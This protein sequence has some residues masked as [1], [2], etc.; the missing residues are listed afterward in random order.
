M[1]GL[2]TTTA[3]AVSLTALCA[4]A[5]PASAACVDDG[6][7]VTCTGPGNA[8]ISD[9]TDGKSFTIEP[10]AGI[11]PLNGRALTLSGDDQSVLNEGL[12]ESLDDEAVRTTGARLTFENAGQIRA[13][14]DRGIRLQAGAD[15][16]T[17]VNRAR[18]TILT[19]DQAIRADNGDLL[20]NLRV[21]NAGTITS[22]KGRAIQS[23][24]PGTTVINTGDLFGGEEVIEARTDFT[25]EN[26]GTI[27]IIDPTIADEDGVQFASGR[28]D[29]HGLIQGTDD[30]IDVDE[31]I[32]NNH[33]GGVIQSLPAPG[34]DGGNGIDADDVLQ[35][36]DGD[37]PAGLLTIDNAGLI[38]GAKAIG[39]DEN[40]TAAI[41]VINS[42]TLRGTSGVA[43]DLAPLQEDSS[44][45]LSG[46]SQI[47]GDV[48]FGS[49]DDL[50][51]VGDVTSG[52]LI[53]SAFDGG[54]GDNTVRFTD[55]MLASVTTAMFDGT[56][57]SLSL[58]TENGLI[59]GNFQ[60][61]GFWQF[62]DDEA[63]STAQLRD[64]LPQA[65]PV[66]LP[67]GLPLLVTALGG[68]AWLRRRTG[69]A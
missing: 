11:G 3:M 50:V 62:G 52:P 12:I 57:I 40:R 37:A 10:G 41:D 13:T 48:I 14:D 28:V 36:P 7:T 65:T 26:R 18:A 39:V 29:N 68:L 34:E 31:G 9:A 55:L 56:K 54:T 8:A 53:N 45:T 30:G 35:T 2:T 67:T 22:T 61:F 58:A 6:T 49:G 20:E 27:Q 59:S 46:D 17:I 5:G 15:D 23:R 19:E 47:F 4:F 25:L 66:P 43:I 69:R 44:L 64:S 38:E 60:N 21:E 32:I 24:G 16:A 63:L 42:G 33:V 51:T 1:T